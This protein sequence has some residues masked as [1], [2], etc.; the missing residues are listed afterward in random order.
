MRQLPRPNSVSLADLTAVAGE[1]L[2]NIKEA[3]NHSKDIFLNH[4]S[5]SVFQFA[6]IYS[7][8]SD[9]KI[10]PFPY[11]ITPQHHSLQLS[12]IPSLS[13]QL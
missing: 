2:I 7:G 6:L 9:V 11:D 5:L 3:L 10:S 13:V 4:G 1:A 8:H 12:F